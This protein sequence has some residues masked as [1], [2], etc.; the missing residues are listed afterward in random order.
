MPISQAESNSNVRVLIDYRP[1][2]RTRTGVGEWVHCLVNAL[3]TEVPSSKTLDLTIFSSSWKHRLGPTTADVSSI[4]RRIP[5]GLLNFCWHRLKWPPVEAVTGVQF[6][7]VHSPHPLLIPTRG[8]A[9]VITIHDLDF[10]DHPERTSAEIRRDYQSLVREHAL[11]ADRVVVPSRHTGTEVQRRLGVSSEAITLCP[12]GAP[13]WPRRSHWPRRGHILYVGT[14]SPRKNIGALLDAY[15]ILTER[16]LELPPMVLTGP[17]P[18]EGRGTLAALTKPPFHGRVHSSGYVTKS[19]LRRYYEEASLLVLPSLNEGFGLPALE[20]MTV[21]VPVIVANRGAL[22]EIV[23]DAGLLIEP[24][25]P[26]T[27][28]DAI[29]RILTDARLAQNCINRGFERAT[30]YSWHDSAEQ[31]R[32][33]Y[34]QAYYHA[35]RYRRA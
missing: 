33:A 1:A 14:L 32:I 3:A 29:E 19:E 11:K 21:G 12:N 34:E 13:D 7:V 35:N 25:Q 24:T 20:A 10:L 6:D 5:V 31:L 16:H 2:L 26:I 17:V 9:Q 23:E 27:L 22:P 18:P 15:Q 4:D 28:A 30:T 8:A